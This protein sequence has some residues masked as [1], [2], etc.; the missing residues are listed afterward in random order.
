MNESDMQAKLEAFVKAAQAVVDA[1][2]AANFPNQGQRLTV[3]MGKRYARI[4]K[5]STGL[6]A[7]RSAY[8]FVDMTN[9]DVL[10]AASWKVPAKGARGS[11]LAANVVAGVTAHGA[12]YR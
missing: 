5:T 1:H 9:G 2:Y 3:E 11:I 6:G 8:C 10:K 7:S 4:V 12:M